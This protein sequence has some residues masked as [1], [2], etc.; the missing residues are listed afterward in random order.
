MYEKNKEERERGEA[1]TYPSK[2]IAREYF[3]ILIRRLY[4][5]EC[6]TF[7]R[8]RLLEGVLTTFEGFTDFVFYRLTFVQKRFYQYV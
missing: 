1:C 6:H 5:Y 4:F 7:M 2:S 8:D 3:Y